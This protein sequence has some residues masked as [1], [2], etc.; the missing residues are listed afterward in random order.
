MPN[1]AAGGVATPADAALVMVL[2]LRYLVQTVLTTA[3]ALIA[4]RGIKVD[5]A[6][7]P[8]DDAKTYSLLNNAQT[9]GVFQLESGGM[10]DL[11]RATGK[12]NRKLAYFLLALP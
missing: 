1:F 6:S 12:N 3:V 9:L 5:L 11:C 10:R 4:G 8:L 2:W 7:L